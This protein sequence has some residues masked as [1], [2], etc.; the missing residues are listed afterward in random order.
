M[1]QKWALKRETFR[2]KV[3]EELYEFSV[4][5]LQSVLE[6]LNRVQREVRDKR[7]FMRPERDFKKQ[8]YLALYEELM[9]EKYELEMT[10]QLQHRIEGMK[11]NDKNATNYEQ[12]VRP[13]LGSQS[14]LVDLPLIIPPMVVES[15]RYS[16]HVAGVESVVPLRSP[17]ADKTMNVFKTL[18]DETKMYPG[19]Q[20]AGYDSVPGFTPSMRSGADTPMEY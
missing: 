4:P 9:Q 11:I 19:F 7:G 10:R 5:K 6:S 1:Q 18:G 15:A 13:C 14:S 2:Q 12:I 8:Q 17:R 20:Y 16:P 3:E